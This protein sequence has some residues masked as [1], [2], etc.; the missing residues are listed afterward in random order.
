MEKLLPAIIL[1]VCRKQ[2]LD[3][4]YDSKTSLPKEKFSVWPYFDIIQMMFD[5]EPRKKAIFIGVVVG[6]VALT[7]AFLIYN[8]S[9]SSDLQTVGQARVLAESLE[10]Y[11]DKFNAYPVSEKVDVES[12][13]FITENGINEQGK[14]Y[15]YR[16]QTEWPRSASY[17]SNGQNYAIDFDLS[18]RWKIW[19]LDKWSGGQCR[20]IDNILMR[21]VA[22]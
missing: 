4:I 2:F 11:F 12:I 15:Y 18:N 3:S 7:T 8:Q 22:E 19:G 17:T 10:Q 9:K 14:I 21:C 16:E 13:S 1:D 6:L 20:I 5:Y